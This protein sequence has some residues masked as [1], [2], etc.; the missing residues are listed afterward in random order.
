MS[1]GQTGA[2]R[3]ALDFAIAHA[4]PH[5]GWCPQGRRAEDGPIPGQYQLAETFI[6]D[7]LQRTEW[8]VRDT[9]G[10]VIFTVAAM[11]TGG[12]ERTAEFAARHAKPFIHLSQ[13]SVMGTKLRREVAGGWI[14][15]QWRMSIRD[16]DVFMASG[17]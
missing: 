8:N 4:I 12:S 2:D 13:P 7:Y 6:G 17:V 15:R 3:A 5:G 9:D 10:T 11:L 1:G 14:S 16:P